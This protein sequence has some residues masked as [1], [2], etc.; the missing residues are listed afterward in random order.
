V[1]SNTS[2]GTGRLVH[3]QVE[4]NSLGASHLN[5]I[6]NTED[7][8]DAGTSKRLVVLSIAAAIAATPLVWFAVDSDA[9]DKLLR[10]TTSAAPNYSATTPSA[11]RS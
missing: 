7:V 6:D 2:G 3:G 5:D 11:S 10:M 8:M 4:R 1:R 9:G